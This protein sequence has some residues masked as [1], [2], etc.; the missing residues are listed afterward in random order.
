VELSPMI[1]L[2]M[3]SVFTSVLSITTFIIERRN[4]IAERINKQ[5]ETDFNKT[6]V[7]LNAYHRDHEPQILI[8]MLVCSILILVI[9]V[10]KLPLVFSIFAVL[11]G[12]YFPYLVLNIYKNKRTTRLESQFEIALLDMAN[13]VRT[14]A[15]L[16]QCFEVAK[17]EAPLPL[18]GELEIV[19]NEI[20]MG[21][22]VDD[23]LRSLSRRVGSKVVDIA[24]NSMMIQRK[25]GGNLPRLLEE[26]SKRL[27]ID[28]NLKSQLRAASVQQKTQAIIIS[29]FPLMFM[30][31]VSIF[32]PHYL[33]YLRSSVGTIVI[34]YSVISNVAGYLL[35]RRFTSTERY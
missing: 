4:L 12:I 7:N 18:K 34:A 23:T 8:S 9:V 6:R 29:I 20:E 27:R 16:V 13:A 11:A 26:I 17:D 2:I 14:G 1:L 25:T 28:N 31:V 5:L 3:F 32:N 24:I 33:E 30:L 19:I 15:N 22:D 21:R 35:I 10:L